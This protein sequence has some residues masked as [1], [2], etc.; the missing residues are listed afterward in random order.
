MAHEQ[1]IEP[2]LHL[3]DL[4]ERVRGL[5]LVRRIRRYVSAPDV[6]YVIGIDTCKVS[7]LR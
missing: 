1:L 3:K 4:G 7:G 2:S 6:T 5:R